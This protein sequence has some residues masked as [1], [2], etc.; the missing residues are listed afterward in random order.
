MPLILSQ[1]SVGKE[2]FL[3]E[4]SEEIKDFQR[5]IS[6]IVFAQIMESTKL[7]KRKLEKLS[8]VMLLKKAKIPFE[9]VKYHKNGKPFLDNGLHLSF[10]HSGEYSTLLVDKNRCG[11]DIEY[12]SEKI[13]RIAPK[14][15]HPEEKDLF[16]TDEYLY[17]IWSIK[18]AIFKY[19][20][21]GVA[22]RDH[23]QVK[24]IDEV[25]KRAFAVY[26]GRHGKGIF[27]M[28]LLRIKKYY[29]AY[30]KT[31]SIE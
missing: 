25:K 4:I 2:L 20:G 1:E 19:F 29:L 31:Y 6:P 26:N 5:I 17:W 10:S 30:T 28:K 23:I 7:E 8:Q 18:E 14:F 9:H 22:F 11:L 16:N 27:E 13:L 12:Q 3:W 15:T 24:E 21:E